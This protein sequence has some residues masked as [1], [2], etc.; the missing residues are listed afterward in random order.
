MS[1]AQV[2]SSPMMTDSGIGGLLVKVASQTEELH[3]LR[4]RI[5]SV[6]EAL[7]GV[8]P[9]AADA[10]AEPP[11]TNNLEARLYASQL[12]INQLRSVVERLEGARN[13]AR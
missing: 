6:C 9:L 1:F 5:E 3:T 4:N 12:A 8:T 2:A 7:Y 10:K 11:P 13:T